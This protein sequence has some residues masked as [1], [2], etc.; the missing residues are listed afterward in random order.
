MAEAWH[1]AAGSAPAGVPGTLPAPEDRGLDVD[2]VVELAR[3]LHG[4]APL[5]AR[6]GWVLATVAMLAEA[7]G[8]AYVAFGGDV[9][10]SWPDPAPS[11]SMGRGPRHRA[12]LARLL[13]SVDDA[14]VGV[15]GGLAHVHAWAV[16]GSD[17]RRCGALV[18]G[19]RTARPLPPAALAATRAIAAHL[20]AALDREDTYRQFQELEAAQREVVHQLQEAV[21][22]TVPQVPETEL[23]VYYLAADPQEPTGGDLYDWRRLADGSVHLAV[24]DVIGKGVAATKDALAVAHALRMLVLDSVPLDAVVRRADEILVAQNPDLVATVVL[25]HYRPDTGELTLA[26]GGHPPPLLLRADGRWELLEPRGIPIGFPGAGSEGTVSVTLGRSDTV[27][28][29]TDG[30]IES[31]KDIVAGLEGLV[32]AGGEVSDYPADHL[33]RALVHR[34]IAGGRRRDDT[35]AL[36]LRR[37]SPAPAVPRP[38]LPPFA[39]SFGAHPAAVGLARHLLADW[40]TSEAIDQTAVDDLLLVANELCAN[41]VVAAVDG[42]VVL[43]AR[44]EDDDVVLEVEGGAR[45]LHPGVGRTD[46]L[47][48]PEPM[49]ERGRGLFLVEALSDSCEV[50]AT[51]E[52][53]TV[54]RCRKTA[55]AF[56]G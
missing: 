55:V 49:A 32:R 42:D 12:H 6:V 44:L 24:V 46:D 47:E 52:G 25:G 3:T 5:E 48:Y 35:V 40:L 11:E 2:L 34:A 13:D 27:V 31:S 16:A 54:V 8:A 36:V 39:H 15:L 22:P 28:L 33:A 45:D 53:R 43:R 19:N 30:L 29:Y 23:G 37:R 41:A 20:G 14:E 18:V 10:Y 7:D 50:A 26:A 17:G 56:G 51:E 1:T 4:N 38:H 21:R 9:V